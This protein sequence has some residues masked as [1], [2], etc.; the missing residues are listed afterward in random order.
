MLRFISL[1]VIVLA[2][3]GLGFS[4]GSREEELEDLVEQIIVEMK[5]H[6][7]HHVTDAAGTIQGVDEDME[8]LLDEIFNL[9]S[10]RT[11][12]HSHEGKFE[13]VTDEMDLELLNALNSL[14]SLLSMNHGSRRRRSRSR[15][16]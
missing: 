10:G 9:E 16:S 15:V 13:V 2:G 14:D 5:D 11:T 4:V 12:S 6:S 7:N 1:L 8:E 3:T